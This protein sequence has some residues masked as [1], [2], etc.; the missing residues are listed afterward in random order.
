MAIEEKKRK[1]FNRPAGIPKR[2]K[3]TYA[4]YVWVRYMF[5]RIDGIEARL[6]ELEETV[7]FI[8]ER[9]DKIKKGEEDV[10]KNG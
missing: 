1:K 8:N 6:A 4:Q 5:L 10:R 3:Q 9:L 7:R 2:N